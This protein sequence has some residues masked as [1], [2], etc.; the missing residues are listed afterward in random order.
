MGD[1][2][3]KRQKD[4]IFRCGQTPETWL[5]LFFLEIVKKYD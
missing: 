1:I 3:P 2:C 4:G 5:R